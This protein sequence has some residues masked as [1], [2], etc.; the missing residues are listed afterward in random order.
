MGIS[1][2]D[3]EI[4]ALT[5]KCQSY[6]DEREQGNTSR[7]AQNKYRANRE[8]LDKLIRTRWE[9]TLQHN[10]DLAKEISA[11]KLLDNANM[12]KMKRR[13]KARQKKLHA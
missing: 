5:E 2:L 12:R 8:N 11:G 9:M 3:Q 1:T 4:K 10:P 7:E 13:E 6:I